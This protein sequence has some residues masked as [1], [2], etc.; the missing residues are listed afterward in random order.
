MMNNAILTFFKCLQVAKHKTCLFCTWMGKLFLSI[1]SFF[2]SYFFSVMISSV[3]NHSLIPLHIYVFLSILIMQAIIEAVVFI[4]SMHFEKTTRVDLKVTLLQKILTLSPNVPEL[5]NTAKNTEILYSETNAVTSFLL[6]GGNIVMDFISVLVSSVVVLLYNRWIFV[7]IIISIVLYAFLTIAFRKKIKRFNNIIRDE[8][9]KNFKFIRDVLMHYLIIDI[10]GAVSFIT[11]KFSSHAQEIK[12]TTIDREVASLILN[13][14]MMIMNGLTVAFIIIFFFM[15]SNEIDGSLVF[16]LACSRIL[17]SSLT[18]L[19]AY[20]TTVYPQLLSIERF[21][22]LYNLKNQH[23]SVYKQLE[24]NKTLELKSVSFGYESKQIIDNLSVQFENNGIYL[25]KGKNGSGKTTL[26]NLIAGIYNPTGGEI[27][28]NGND[29]IDYSYPS[30]AEK[31]SFCPQ[32]DTLFN[33]TLSENI[34]MKKIEETSP[35]ELVLF[36]KLMKLFRLDS[37]VEIKESN[38]STSML[39]DGQALSLGQIKKVCLARTLLRDCDIL[40]LD[41]PLNGLDEDSRSVL[42]EYLDILSRK[43]KIIIA[44]NTPI[45]CSNINSI[46][47]LS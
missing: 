24:S 37:I 39:C 6:S 45:S 5:K 42:C 20:S 34:L 36:E 41:E 31:V 25:I 27:L 28:W 3:I 7:W 19:I 32:T 16:L 4:Q 29:I 35:S 43:K 33:M 15:N 44:T 18:K 23:N 26:L 47:N 11:G 30:I 12:R 46:L 21:F 8:T 38:I 17:F 2:S 10:T 14:F 1:L 13:I 22:S 40:L 9:D